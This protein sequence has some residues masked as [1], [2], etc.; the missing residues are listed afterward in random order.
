[1]QQVSHITLYVLD[2]DRAKEFYTRKLGF[3]VGTDQAGDGSR[4]LTV[5]P[6]EQADLY[7][8]LIEPKQP[9]FDAET[10]EQLKSLIA[11]GALGEIFLE[12]RDCRAAYEDLRARGVEF[13]QEPTERPYGIEAS[14]RDDSGNSLVLLQH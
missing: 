4:W 5:V 13:V 12:T 2:Q 11:R 9:D 3:G 8:A 6:P 1:M 14:F 10:V 7:I